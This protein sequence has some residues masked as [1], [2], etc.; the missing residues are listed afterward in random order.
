[1]IEI[2]EV[3]KSQYRFR[4][5]NRV[6]QAVFKSVVFKDREAIRP[7]LETLTPLLK[8]QGIIERKTD[9]QGMFHFGLRDANGRIIGHSTTYESEA[10]MENAIKNL[11]KLLQS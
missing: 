8:K 11:H 1:M 2:D 3:G 5:V 7:L 6:G 9:H 4:V 10:G